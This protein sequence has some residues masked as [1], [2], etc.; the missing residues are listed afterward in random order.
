MED[1]LGVGTR[2]ATVPTTSESRLGQC[3]CGCV[4]FRV[5]GPPAFCLL[6][7]CSYCRHDHGSTQ[8]CHLA[9]WMGSN[10]EF[11]AGD[12][13]LLEYVHPKQMHNTSPFTSTRC[14]CK[15]CG[16]KVC[17]KF[18][19]GSEPAMGFAVQCFIAESEA[20][21]GVGGGVLP[22]NLLAQEH[23][24]YASRVVDST[25][26]LPKYLDIPGHFGGTGNLYQYVPT[27]NN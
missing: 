15:T 7:H 19:V 24:Y 12:K 22:A 14:H 8:P 2:A 26:D 10:I 23:I 16:S 6:C 9:G 4:L 18:V 13:N 21:G 5:T 1:L 25:D 27:T 17:N 11:L 3:L 20:L